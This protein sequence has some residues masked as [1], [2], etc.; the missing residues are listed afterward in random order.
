MVQIMIMVIIVMMAIK[1]ASL[2]QI[3]G[4]FKFHFYCPPIFTII[5]VAVFVGTLSIYRDF[6]LITQVDKAVL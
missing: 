2:I 1:S 3:E 4:V 5:I 6:I